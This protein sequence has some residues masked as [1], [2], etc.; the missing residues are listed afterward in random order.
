MT[1]KIN[2]PID[3]RTMTR[4]TILLVED[5]SDDEELTLGALRKSNIMND[6]VVAH[7]GEEAL[8]HLFAKSE[9]LDREH[10]L[11]PALVLLD[12]KLPKMNGLDVLR[13]IRTHP[14]TRALPVVVLTGSEAEQDNCAA[15]DLGVLSYMHKP[16]DF[17]K[18]AEAVGN[19]GMA[20]VL[21]N[22]IPRLSVNSA[23]RV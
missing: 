9:S 18:I 23:T 5:D 19:L 22:E 21:S 1:A 6:V 16:I 2:V 4:R 20:W 10:E 15:H 12:L 14:R 17:E 8:A 7:D 3:D 13:R 11:L